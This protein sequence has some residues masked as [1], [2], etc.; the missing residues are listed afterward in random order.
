[1]DSYEIGQLL[2]YVTACV[3]FVLYL[4]QV[5]H[6]YQ[7]QDTHSLNT[8]FILLQMLSCITT[9]SYGAILNEKPIMVS[10]ISIFVSVSALGYAKWVL[11]KIPNSASRSEYS[12]INVTRFPRCD[13]Q[14]ST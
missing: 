5:I 3:N 1:M 8:N 6:V 11:Y 4:P 9:F 12:P 10:S 2:G 13:S 14:G 7:I